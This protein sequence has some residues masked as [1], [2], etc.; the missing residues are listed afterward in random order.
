[1]KLS[2][3]LCVVLAAG[4]LVLAGIASAATITLLKPEREGSKV[5]HTAIYTDTKKGQHLDFRLCAQRKQ[6]GSWVNTFCHRFVFDIPENDF[7]YKA[8][9]LAICENGRLRTKLTKSGGA[10]LLSPEKVVT[11]C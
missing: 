6:D 3:V 7:T 9:L 11:G 4:V 1:V 2:A 8:S 10:V 5:R